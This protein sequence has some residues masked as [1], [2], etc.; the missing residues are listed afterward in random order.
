[1]HRISFTSYSINNVEFL[2]E[3]ISDHV[4][5]TCCPL[6]YLQSPSEKQVCGE[7]EVFRETERREFVFQLHMADKPCQHTPVDKKSFIIR[8]TK[9]PKLTKKLHVAE[10]CSMSFFTLFYTL[11]FDYDYR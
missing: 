5:K 3:I 8:S 2:L 10:N 9:M 1:M 11:F 4:K 7:A 6:R